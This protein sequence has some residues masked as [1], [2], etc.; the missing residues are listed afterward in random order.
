[1]R[2]LTLLGVGLLFVGSANAALLF[3]DSDGKSSVDL[4]PGESVEIDIML[5][6]RAIDPG[7]FAEF[8]D[9]GGCGGADAGERKVDGADRLDG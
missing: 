9:S 4:A 6:I 2:L 3:L 1:M 8:A 5:T 7:F